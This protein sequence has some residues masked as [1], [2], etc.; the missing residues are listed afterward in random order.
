MPQNDYIDE[1][2]KKHGRRLDHEERLR[3]RKA[4]EH[5]TISKK[6]QSLHGIK[7]KLFNKQR[8]K[9]KIQLKKDLNL[10]QEKKNKQKVDENENKGNSIPTY[11]LDRKE[12]TSAKVLSN[13]IKQKRKEKVA[14]WTVPLPKVRA[15]DESEMFKV[16]KSGK[17]KGK[18]IIIYISM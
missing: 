9:Q 4:R 11:L 7:A 18:F 15:V 1:S 12:Q 10:K 17:R 3:K 16:I 13:L 14:K 6:A 8:H 2:I 5:K